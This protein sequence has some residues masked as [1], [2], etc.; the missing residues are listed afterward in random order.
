MTWFSD[1]FKTFVGFTR[2][3]FAQTLHDP[4]WTTRAP[5]ELYGVRVFD[6]VNAERTIA[7]TGAKQHPTSVFDYAAT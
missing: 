7:A 1:R 2:K 4:R 3:E 5:A 6:L